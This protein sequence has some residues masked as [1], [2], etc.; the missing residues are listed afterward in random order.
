MDV[1]ALFRAVTANPAAFGL[2]VS[3]GCLSGTAVCASPD[4]Y[5]YW[6]GTHPTAAGHRLLAA[7]AEDYLHYGDRGAATA[8]EADDAESLRRRAY[9]SDF[10]L[11][12]GLDHAP[13]GTRA[14]VQA[15]GQHIDIDAR[16]AVPDASGPRRRHPLRGRPHLGRPAPGPGVQHRRGPGRRPAPVVRHPVLWRGRLLRLDRRGRPG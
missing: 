5:L 9:D 13:E 7:L 1:N 4:S 12:T 16:G 15:D 10:E 3:S 14:G 8:L 11:L 2:T 6:D